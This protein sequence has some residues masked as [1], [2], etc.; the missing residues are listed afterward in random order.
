MTRC[1]WVNENNPIY[2]AYHD[3]EWGKPEHDDRMLFELLILEGFQAG[4]S[5]EC[6]L[7]KREAFQKAFDQFDAVK[8]SQYDADKVEQLLQNREIVRNRRKI[9]A[10]VKNAE[11]FLH[12]QRE[13][14]SFDTFIWGF[15]QGKVIREDWRIRTTSPL[16]DEISWV[17]K[18]RGMTFVGSTIIYSYLQAIGILNGHET[19]CD[20]CR[21]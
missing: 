3:S 18:K 19:G 12:L 11:V 21:G 9:A 20:C 14:G 4:L 1:A 17:L 8:I 13:Y 5:W 16:S 10:A 6:I 15:T 2:V 7:N